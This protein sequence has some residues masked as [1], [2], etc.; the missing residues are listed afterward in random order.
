MIADGLI[1]LRERQRLARVSVLD[2]LEAARAAMAAKRGS[3]GTPRG[4]YL[5]QA[6][7]RLEVRTAPQPAPTDKPPV[8]P[9]ELAKQRAILGERDEED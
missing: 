5:P 3:G 4:T 7:E 2:A 6:V 8:D 9:A 1:A